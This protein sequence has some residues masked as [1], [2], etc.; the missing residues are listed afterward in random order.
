[1]KKFRP[2]RVAALAATT[3]LLV[4]C[5]AKSSKSPT[6]PPSNPVPPAPVVS[7]IVSISVSQTQLTAGS[8]TSATITVS[9][10]RSDNGQPVPNGTVA[11]VTT[12]LGS[13]VSFPSGPTSVDLD[14]VNGRASVAFFAGD[15]F[16]IATIRAAVT[17][18]GSTSVAT[19]EI[20]IVEAATLFIQSVSPG[21]GSPQGGDTV[22]I[23]GGGFATPLRVTFDGVPAT[24]VSSNS[25]QIRVI[26]PARSAGPLS[27][28]ETDP[29]DISVTI[30]YGQVDQKADLLPSGFIY[31]N[32][33]GTT[34]PQIFSVTP[35]SGPNEGGTQVAI[36][37]DGFEEPLQVLFGSGS[38]ASSFD[39]IEAQ[40]IS[41]S[42]TRVVVLTPPAISFGQDLQ[43]EL[44][45]ILVK[46]LDN[47]KFAI[48]TDAFKYG[49]S[50]LITSN[51]PSQGPASGGTLVTIF[52]QGFDEPVAVAI[53][54]SGASLGQSPV[55]VSG[56]EIVI[57]TS[58]PAP[59]SQADCPA[60]PSGPFRV[61]NIET[62]DSATGGGCDYLLPR[63][64]INS[65]SPNFG[66][67]GT[68]VTI[69]GSGFTAPTPGVRV[70]FG[71]ATNGSSASITSSSSTQIVARVPTPPVSF[72]FATEPCDS[73]GDGEANGERN[74]PTPISVTVL[75]LDGW[76]CDDTF[77]NGF[78]LSPPNTT[79]TG[80]TTP[81]PEVASFTFT[82]GPN[83]SLTVL[84][85]DTSS[86]SPT[87]WSWNFGDPA[88]GVAN[89]SALQNPVHTFSA[90]GTYT[91]SLTVGTSTATEFVTVP[92]P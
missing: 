43:N 17:F 12:T 42:R 40:V 37:G 74:I 49:V 14:L 10:V 59:P 57:S 83:P 25:S 22:T 2:L 24:I 53:T 3:V 27:G 48:S 31:T 20:R 78:T 75:N 39:G 91:V 86:G 44:V 30:H 85:Q 45:D 87:S 90:A 70:L 51:S 46:N 82:V 62:G 64:L 16:G 89:T 19:A 4:A 52:G 66:S 28:N 36:Q 63:P 29:A 33:G 8:T 65:I 80:D 58:A 1:M 15:S 38:S 54:L 9:A 13:L 81:T 26:T 23:I 79:C 92:G 18:G 76:D 55:S 60:N 50:V 32:G 61:T 11:T 6:Q 69:T 56:T 72:E 84:F 88:S 41:I 35:A 21:T 34:Q 68:T 5:S 67:V 77:T 71:G 7:A 47:G 73:N